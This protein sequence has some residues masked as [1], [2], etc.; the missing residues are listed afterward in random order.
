MTLALDVSSGFGF[1]WSFGFHF[2]PKFT[3]WL[4]DDESAGW[5]LCEVCLLI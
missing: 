3:L 5:L 4:P 2:C 1:V